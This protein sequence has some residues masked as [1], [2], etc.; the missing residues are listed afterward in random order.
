MRLPPQP[1]GSSPKRGGARRLLAESSSRPSTASFPGRPLPQEE[2]ARGDHLCA[3]RSPQPPRQRRGCAAPP[4]ASPARPS[5][6]SCRKSWA[7]AAGAATFRARFLLLQLRRR[8]LCPG[9]AAAGPPARGAVT[10]AAQRVPSRLERHL[11]RPRCLPCGGP[12][13]RS[14][15]GP[16]VS[17]WPAAAAAARSF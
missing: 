17:E 5:L 9:K 1:D 4:L 7:G 3:R 2:S 8:R 12:C 11:Q 6:R 10:G 13:R 14:A 16:R 15:P